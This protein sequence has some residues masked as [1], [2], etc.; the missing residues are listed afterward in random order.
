M[1]T[2]AARTFLLMLANRATSHAVQPLVY[3]DEARALS[4]YGGTVLITNLI[5]WLINNIDRVIVG[6][7]FASREIGL[8]ATTYNMLQT[9]TSSLLG[10]VQPVFFAASSRIADDRETIAASYR[11]L[12][13]AVVTYILPVFVAVAAISETFVLG[14]YGPKWHESAALVVPL[15]LAMPLFRSLKLRCN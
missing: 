10:I 4:T 11:A 5:N 7:L 12:I 1:H 13:A 2:I 15:A 8:Y 14:L 6:R 3:H 9:P